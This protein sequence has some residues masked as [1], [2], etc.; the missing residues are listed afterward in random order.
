MHIRSPAE[1]C[2]HIC[3]EG[4]HSQTPSAHQFVQFMDGTELALSS[5]I[6]SKKLNKIAK[7]ENDGRLSYPF[8]ECLS[9]KRSEFHH[10]QCSIAEYDGT[11]SYPFLECLSIKSSHYNRYM[12]RS[13]RLRS[14]STLMM[15]RVQVS[16][17]LVLDPRFKGLGLGKRWGLFH[18]G[19]AGLRVIPGHRRDSNPATRICWTYTRLH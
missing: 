5:Y 9:I 15:G 13:C 14:I 10:T 4:A 11:L 3:N 12:D 1:D 18:A 2:T 7:A 16:G 6:R 19:L 8:L 17:F